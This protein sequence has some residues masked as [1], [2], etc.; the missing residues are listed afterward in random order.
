LIRDPLRATRGAALNVLRDML[1]SRAKQ[2][3]AEELND[4]AAALHETL[5]SDEPVTWL[6]VAALEALGELLAVKSD[7]AWAGELLAKELTG[8]ATYAEQSAAATALSH[9]GGAV[10]TAAVFK[11][12][13]DLPLDEEAKREAVFF[14][15]AVTRHESQAEQALLARL[16]RSIAAR[17]SLEAEII[18]L[19]RLHSEASLPLLMSAAGQAN[20]SP[21]DRHYLAWALGVVGNDQAAMLLAR[22]VRTNDYQAKETALAALE[23]LDSAAAAREVRPLLKTEANLAYKLR[24]A[25]LLARHD[26][27]DGYALAT[28]HLA[29]AEQTPAAALVLAALDDPRTAGELSAIVAAQP[30]RRWHAAALAGLAAIGDATAVQQLRDMLT[31]DRHALAA[32]AAVAAGLAGDMDLLEPLA[33]LAKSRNRRISLASL[34]AL[35]RQLSDVRSSPHGLAAVE[36]GVDDSAEMDRRAPTPAAE[37]PAETVDAIAAAIA[38]LAVDAYAD[39]EVRHEAFA[40]ARLLRGAGYAELLAQLADQ[41]ELEGTPLLTAVQAERRRVR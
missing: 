7:L 41:S 33:D 28:E 6:R 1:A 26:L 32:D 10:A 34:A 5:E 20:L 27:G 12:L 38:S 25:R 13:Q 22:W 40:V 29:D 2:G 9:V 23:T 11:A 35:R 21:R 14:Q 24:L 39:A 31:D 16:E 4:V 37:L 17:A 19:G 8:A 30:D 3:E 36:L 18:A 15:A